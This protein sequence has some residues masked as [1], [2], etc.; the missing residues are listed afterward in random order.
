MVERKERKKDDKNH[1]GK[2]SGEKKD[3]GT[4]PSLIR[5]TTTHI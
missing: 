2:K 1:S 3:V 4:Q 5:Q